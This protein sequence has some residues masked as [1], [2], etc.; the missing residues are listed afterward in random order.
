MFQ[1]TVNIN[2]AFGIIGEV[3]KS[4]T[5]RA[6]PGI[7]DSDGV[8]APN[9]VGRVFTNVAG[10]DGHMVIGGAGV[11]AGILANPKVYPERGTAAGGTL[12]PSLDL[13][14]YAAG[15]EFVYMTTGLVAYFEAAGNIGDTVDFDTATGQ[16]YPRSESYPA[17]GAQ[18]IAFASNVATVT[19]MPAGAPPIGIGSVI[20]SG[21]KQTTVLSLGTG[22]GG[23]GTYNVSAI[24][25]A[26]AAAFSYTSVAPTGRANIPRSRVQFFNIPAAGLGV[27]ELNF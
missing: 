13:P 16:L 2:Q 4:G 11:F 15:V 14:Q 10:A 24:A 9:R 1:S 6:Q 17:T 25:D 7:I 20:T 22:T 18:R 23:N 12:A 26:G 27:V 8:A 21:G 5:L 19:L 3:Y